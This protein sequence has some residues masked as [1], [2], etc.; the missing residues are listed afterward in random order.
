LDSLGDQEEQALNAFRGCQKGACFACGLGVGTS[1]SSDKSQQDANTNT[2]GWQSD[3]PNPL[4]IFPMPDG[5][6]TP[7]LLPGMYFPLELVARIIEEGSPF[8]TTDDPE[9][10]QYIAAFLSHETEHRHLLVGVVPTL[11]RLMASRCYS[12]LANLIKN[13]FH[14]AWWKGILS[15]SNNIENL[16]IAIAPLHEVIANLRSL[17]THKGNPYVTTIGQQSLAFYTKVHGETFTKILYDFSCIIQRL[18]EWF[19]P[20]TIQP[21]TILILAEFILMGQPW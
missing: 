19:T 10:V 3:K 1:V 12:L 2:R 13:G 18:E 8:Y 7:I 4:P 11:M 6:Y 5:F 21:F 20:A 14:P 17:V 16:Y 15:Q 9:L